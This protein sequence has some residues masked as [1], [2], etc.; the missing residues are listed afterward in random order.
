MIVRCNSS[1]EPDRAG[2][3][4]QQS[5]A[6]K[7]DNVSRVRYTLNMHTVLLELEVEVHTTTAV[8]DNQ[9]RVT[10]LR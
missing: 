10:L 5:R 9:Y 3:A 1:S 8:M 2:Q 6:Q 4:V 7:M